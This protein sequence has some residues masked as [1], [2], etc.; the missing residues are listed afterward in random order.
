MKPLKNGLLASQV[1]Q[2]LRRA[3]FSGQFRPGDQIL[4]SH[5]ARQLGVSQTTVREALG[6]LDQM[7]LVHRVP[8]K[9]S[10]VNSLSPDEVRDRLRI[11]V[12]LEGLAWEEA[13][14][15]MDEAAFD[16]LEKKLAAIQFAAAERDYP[17]LADTELDFHRAIWETAGMPTLVHLLDQLTTPLF[18]FITLERAAR[19]IE[20]PDPY[21]RHKAVIEALRSGDPSVARQALEAHLAPSY[22]DLDEA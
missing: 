14:K 10:F 17:Q 20:E 18:A 19:N 3:I 1:A 6:H 13:A 15:R 9:G 5:I 12:L 7:G 16:R 22:G 4:E 8:N 2:T 11:R 21:P